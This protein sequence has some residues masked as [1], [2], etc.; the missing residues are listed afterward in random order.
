[1]LVDDHTL[2]REGVARLLASEPDLEMAA[3]CASVAEALHTLAE[4]DIDAVL[5]DF[6]LG[7]ERGSPFLAQARARGFQGPIVILTGG[8]S[9]IEAR[10]LLTQ[11]AAGIFLKH[12]S[13]P[14][15]AKCIR[16][17]MQ[18]QL[19]IDQDHVRALVKIPPQEGV[20]KFTEREKFVLR[21]ILEGLANK[22]IAVR[23]DSTE[24]AVKGVLQQLFQKTGV[25]T[26]SQLVRLALE[27]Y[28]DQI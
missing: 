10:E 15:L 23:L 26:R 21:G 2:F 28:R 27:E 18:G 7:N 1:L 22:E 20:K 6:D 4:K 3:H 17:T 16:T 12:N 24:S 11:G 14:L 13:P 25:R 5:L 9:S 8:V 19:W